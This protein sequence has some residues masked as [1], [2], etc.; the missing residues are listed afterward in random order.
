MTDPTPSPS[1]QVSG[2]HETVLYAPDL[3]RAVEFYRSV[4]GLSA[5]MT[6]SDRG[7]SFRVTPESVLLLFEPHL[8]ATQTDGQV[9]S[10]GATG[11]GHICFSTPPGTLKDWRRRFE[12]LGVAIEMERGWD[13]GAR[14]IYVRD[15]AGNSVE[16]ADGD[17]WGEAL[18][19][20]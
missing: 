5:M 19:D 15:P 1:L 12:K 9:P 4:I 6:L 14:S 20:G 2:I 11:P 18:H 13:T 3:P 16:I 7:A 8:A 17:I 10:H